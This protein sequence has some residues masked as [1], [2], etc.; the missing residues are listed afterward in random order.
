M[1]QSPVKLNSICTLQAIII[2]GKINHYTV[3]IVPW[4][5]LQLQVRISSSH[6]LGGHN[7]HLCQVAVCC[8]EV[9]L[10][11]ITF[12]SSITTHR[13]TWYHHV[14]PQDKHSSDQSNII[15]SL[16]DHCTF[17]VRDILKIMECAHFYLVVSVGEYDTMFQEQ[18]RWGN[19]FQWC[20][21]K[22]ASFSM[23][24]STGYADIFLATKPQLI[25]MY[26]LS[27]TIIF[28]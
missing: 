12:S 25:T 18:S 3:K 7:Y 15:E 23:I 11:I 5:T 10:I 26:W 4:T 2:C 13:N 21:M 20:S 27:L 28:T 1:V 9:L 16:D 19:I 17:S 24:L 14:W 8:H 6:F 22:I